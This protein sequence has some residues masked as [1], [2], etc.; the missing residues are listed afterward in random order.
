MPWIDSVSAATA[1]ARF[2]GTLIAVLP[3]GA[4]AL[5]ELAQPGSL[6][7]LLRSPV[8][9]TMLVLAVVLQVAGL[10]AIRRLARLPGEG[11][12]RTAR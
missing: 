2:T 4:A 5:S 8:T 6:A 9:A 1:Q 10:A 3:L 7:A 11:R 12:P